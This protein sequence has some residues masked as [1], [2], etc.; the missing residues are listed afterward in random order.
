MSLV[1]LLFQVTASCMWWGHN[2]HSFYAHLKA[3]ICITLL[4]PCTNLYALIYNS[5]ESILQ[6]QT[7]KHN[8]EVIRVKMSMQLFNPLN[9]SVCEILDFNICVSWGL[10]T[11]GVS[12]SVFGWG[13]PDFPP[14]HGTKLNQ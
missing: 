10:Q 8:L 9:H 1:C 2:C 12:R 3:K 4:F 7:S 13:F 11:Y 14:K 6:A 5:Y